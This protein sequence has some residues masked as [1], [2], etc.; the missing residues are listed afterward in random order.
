[1]GAYWVANKDNVTGRGLAGAFIGGAIPG[2]VSVLAGPMAGSAARLAGG[3]ASKAVT[4]LGGAYIN[5][6][7]SFAANV[8]S[9]VISND[10][11]VSW[12]VALAVG[13]LGFATNTMAQV[14]FPIKGVPTLNQAESFM[15]RTL[16]GMW[17]GISNRY[18]APNAA[19]LINGGVTSAAVDAAPSLLEAS[20]GGRGAGI[21]GDISLNL[22]SSGFGTDETGNV[23]TLV[24]IEGGGPTWVTADNA[25]SMLSQGEDLVYIR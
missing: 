23:V 10:N 4:T 2:A 11:G 1:M 13:A 14:A 22:E 5:A 20:F 3:V 25:N 24:S 16:N 19:A 6:N 21:I 15:P 17:K 7:S 18:A 8:A 12:D 9:Q